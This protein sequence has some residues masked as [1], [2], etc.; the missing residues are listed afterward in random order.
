[1]CVLS[2]LGLQRNRNVLRAHASLALVRPAQ[3][4]DYG[5][6]RTESR[7]LLAKQIV[8]GLQTDALVRQRLDQVAV[9]LDAAELLSSRRKRKTVDREAERC[10]PGESS[11]PETSTA[12][13]SIAITR[14]SG[15][16]RGSHRACALQCRHD[17]HQEMLSRMRPVNRAIAHQLS[18][19]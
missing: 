9:R 19:A 12:P 7:L 3:V 11:S 8:D 16:R 5:Q 4:L 17:D 6:A 18:A 2:G 14:D 13:P 10:T 1:L 15:R